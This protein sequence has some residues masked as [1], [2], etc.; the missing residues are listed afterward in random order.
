MLYPVPLNLS[1]SNTFESTVISLRS[2]ISIFQAG[3]L[4][5]ISKR[6]VLA[7]PAVGNLNGKV[8]LLPRFWPG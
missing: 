7:R 4:S 8:L 2:L 6:H 3:Q 1:S 5:P